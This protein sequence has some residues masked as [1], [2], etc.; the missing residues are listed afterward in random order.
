MGPA[1]AAGTTGVEHGFYNYSSA[2]GTLQFTLVTDRMTARIR[3]FR[4][5]VLCALDARGFIFASPL[6]LE[7]GV[8]LV[9]IRKAGKLP[10]EC[11]QRTF[12][13][14]YENGDV[15]EIQCGRI[16]SSDRV[17]IIDDILATGGSM[18]GAWE[19][20]AQSSPDSIV[21]FCVLDLYLPGSRE[22]LTTHN[23]DVQS[24]LDVSKWKQQ[25]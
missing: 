5:T 13:K 18:R 3:E 7:L 8:P 2:N 11:I 16:K 12:D 22:F 10:G 24:L 6:A 15:F 21:G 17:V 19:L 20:V 1:G 23:M 25:S 14:E 9:M 4:P